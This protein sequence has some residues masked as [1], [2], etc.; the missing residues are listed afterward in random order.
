MALQWSW[1]SPAVVLWRKGVA[2]FWC[3]PE[4]K[5]ILG[6]SIDLF[7]PTAAVRACPERAPTNWPG[8]GRPAPYSDGE[9]NSRASTSLKQ[10]G[11]DAA[12]D[13]RLGTSFHRVMH[14]SLHSP[15][16][17][18]AQCVRPAPFCHAH[19]PTS[20]DRFGGARPV[21][22]RANCSGR[23]APLPTRRR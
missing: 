7:Q 20:E 4:A 12:R 19:L 2:W 1:E 17:R 16:C 15:G 21:V 18:G 11:D 22:V 9:S 8:T 3:G 14:T 23:S 5:W 6:M 10:T 13:T